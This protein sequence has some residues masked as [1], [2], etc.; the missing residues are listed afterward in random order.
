MTSRSLPRA[1]RALLLSAGLL[2]TGFA[3]TSLVAPRAQHYLPQETFSD[4][5]AAKTDS[6]ESLPYVHYR[7]YFAEEESHL[8]SRIN[9][10]DAIGKE[11]LPIVQLLNRTVLENFNRGDTLVIPSRFDV[12]W[13]AYSPFPRLYEGARNIEKL[14]VLDKTLQVFAAYEHGKLVR[15]GLANTGEKSA[16]TPSGRFNFNWQTEYKRSSLNP[17]WEM[18]WVMNFHFARGLHIHQYALPTGGP[19]S[20]GCVRLLDPDAKWL[21][22]WIDTWEKNAQGQLVEQGTPLIIIGEVSEYKPSL[23]RFRRAYPELRKVDLPADPMR[24]PP[25]SDQ[26]R[27]FDRL[28]EQR[29]EASEGGT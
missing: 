25:G 21:Y 6:L 14:V 11:N 4:V 27:R 29:A 17:D 3:A 7:Y 23:F 8:W 15:W 22:H 10:T 1:G 18:H 13:R 28:R 26:Q 19:A 5:L 16:Q 12:D 20:H 9:L 24:V 2:L